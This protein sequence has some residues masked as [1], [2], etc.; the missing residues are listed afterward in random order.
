MLCPL[1]RRPRMQTQEEM[2]QRVKCMQEWI[3]G[4]MQGAPPQS[5]IG[6]T[7]FGP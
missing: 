4:K 7:E 5:Q 6:K 2:N 3:P 1:R